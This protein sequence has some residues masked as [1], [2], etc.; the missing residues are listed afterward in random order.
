MA[1]KLIQL[2][3]TT[4]QGTQMLFHLQDCKS[5][6]YVHAIIQKDTGDIDDD[7]CEDQDNDGWTFQARL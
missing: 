7:D 5:L 2:T 4:C 1:T 3:A 6:K